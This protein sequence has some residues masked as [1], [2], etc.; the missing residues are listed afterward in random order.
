MTANT[1][2]IKTSGEITNIT[3]LP[4]T[5]KVLAKMNKKN[6]RGTNLYTVWFVQEPKEE[7][8]IEVLTSRSKSGEITKSSTIVKNQLEDWIERFKR[9]DSFIKE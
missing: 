3:K 4:E 2:K 8:F 5:W 1:K 9:M 6:K 7:W